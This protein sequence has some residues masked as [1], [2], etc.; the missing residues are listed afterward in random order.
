VLCFGFGPTTF[1]AV[2][3]RPNSFIGS[4]KYTEPTQ[5][6]W[7]KKFDIRPTLLYRKRD[8]TWLLRYTCWLLLVRIGTTG[9]RQL[10]SRDSLT[11][12][13]LLLYCGSPR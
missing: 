11:S 12:A 5:D 2:S 13:V 10:H 6:P 7:P 8:R 4:P 3:R 9:P 1:R